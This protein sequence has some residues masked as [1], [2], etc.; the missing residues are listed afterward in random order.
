MSIRLLVLEPSSWSDPLRG[1]LIH[2]SLEEQ[3]ESYYEALS[4]VWGNPNNPSLILLNDSQ[5]LPITRNLE[6]ALRH[7][8]SETTRR[9][10]RVDAICINQ[11]DVQERS[12]QVDIMNKIYPT[13]AS[14]PVFLGTA[15]PNSAMG[16]DILSFLASEN[17]I[18]SHPPWAK[19]A[20]ELALAGLSEILEC[21]WSFRMWTVQEAAL[22]RRVKMMCGQDRFVWQAGNVRRFL[23]RIQYASISPQWKQ[24][25]LDKVNTQHLHELLQ[26]SV[27]IHSTQAHDAD[28]L[29]VMFDL[30]GR[31]VTDLRDAMYGVAGLPRK[32]NERIVPDYSLTMEK[33]FETLRQLSDV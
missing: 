16:L 17:D 10:L 2:A 12:H 7:L 13:A 28:L 1:H 21:H 3:E 6:D 20:P 25:G 19:A 33:T 8:R 15:T 30:R 9:R 14:V 18:D 4:Y 22:A 23:R 26:L 5:I 27:K 32:G 29:D 11:E 24:A 31:Q